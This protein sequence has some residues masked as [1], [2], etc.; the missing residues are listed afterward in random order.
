MA[1]WRTGPGARW[2]LVGV[3]SLLAVSAWIYTLI[4]VWPTVGRA[5]TAVGATSG[6][7]QSD[8]YPTWLGT[9][10]LFWEGRD[11]YSPG[12]TADIQR[13]FYGHALTPDDPI[14]DLQQFVYPLY[15]VFL[16]VPTT[17]VPFAWVQFSYWFIAP[18]LVALTVN[19]WLAALRWPVTRLQ[20]VILTILGVSAPAAIHAITLQQPAVFVA[21][22]MAGAGVCLSRRWYAAAGV[23]LA[24]ATVK[25]QIGLLFALWL[26]GWAASDWRRRQGVL[27]GFGVTMAAFLAGAFAL[28][29]GWVG[30]WL[31]LISA[32][33]SYAAKQSILVWV[34][35]PLIPWVVGIIGLALLGVAWRTRRAEP[36]SLAFGLILALPGVY[37]ILAFPSWFTHGLLILYPAALLVGQYAATLRQQGWAGRIAYTITLDFLLWPWLSALPL[38]LYWVLAGLIGGPAAAISA[39]QLWPVFWVINLL[40]PV[41]LLLPLGL[42][43]WSVVRGPGPQQQLQEAPG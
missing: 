33:P 12:V 6:P 11:P 23:L 22:L 20:R 2:G 16:L 8:L 9:H 26:L 24:C 34:P 5:A 37:S 7:Y 42:L 18:V 39:G 41:V 10:A 40:V 3:V 32:Y 14:K 36:G 43:T 35:A 17:I 1:K 13:G 28:V 19:G 25:P 21:A 4:V 15:I 31:S 29:P 38:L 30:E 27:W